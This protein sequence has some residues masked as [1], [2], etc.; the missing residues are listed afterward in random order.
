MKS[1]FD[2]QFFGGGG[3]SSSKQ[4]RKR[5]PEPE[6]LTNLREGILGKI[7]PILDVY[8]PSRWTD[9]QNIGDQAIQSQLGLLDQVQGSL[10][11][12]DSILEKM[13]GV[14]DSGEIPA[15][16]TERMNA[17]VNKDMQSGMGSMLNS[18][19]GRGVINSSITGQ[20]VSR[21]GQQAA[22][23]F[24]KNYLSAF[25]SVLSGYGSALQ[26]SQGN[27]QSLLGAAQGY[28]GI[29]G[30]AFENA[31]ASL[32]PAYNFWKDWQSSYDNREDYDTVVTQKSK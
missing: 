14:I 23:A 5:D 4:Y 25:N 8:D 24:N 20:G 13:L 12:N 6:G 19:G 15:A 9:A 3:G 21:L 22:D 16:L 31:G 29:P 26:G 28:A 17:A 1:K 11:K 2:I 18:L 7:S 30:A 10:G 32:M 27:T